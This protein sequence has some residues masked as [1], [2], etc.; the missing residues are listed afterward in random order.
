MQH[1]GLHID[2]ANLA[3]AWCSNLYPELQSKRALGGVQPSRLAAAAAVA[4]AA[5]QGST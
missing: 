2:V 3:A 5:A 4:A 1:T